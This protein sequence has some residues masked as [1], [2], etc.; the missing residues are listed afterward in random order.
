[1][2]KTGQAVQQCDDYIRDSGTIWFSGPP[3]W[4]VVL[5]LMIV[6]GLIHLWVLWPCSRQEE[7]KLERTRGI[8]N[9][10]NMFHLSLVNFNSFPE[11]LYNNIYMHLIDQNWVS[12]Y[13]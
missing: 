3:R 4:C 5:I 1:M 11:M 2:K 7:G 12:H 13:F 10:Q 6:G 8:V 9:G